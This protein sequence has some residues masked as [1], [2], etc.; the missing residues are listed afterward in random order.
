VR[1]E[2]RRRDGCR[3]LVDRYRLFPDLDE[4]TSQRVYCHLMPIDGMGLQ[5]ADPM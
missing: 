1:E 4:V 3:L 5:F 2:L